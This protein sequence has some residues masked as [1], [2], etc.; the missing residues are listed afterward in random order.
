[1]SEAP[2][3]KVLAAIV[4]SAIKE[5]SAPLVARVA[6]LEQRAQA[7][8]AGV[9]TA[10]VPDLGVLA[11]IIVSAIKEYTAPMLARIAEIERLKDGGVDDAISV[12]LIQLQTRIKSLEARPAM[13]YK[14]SWKSD[15]SYDEGNMATHH[16]SLWHANE[17]SRGMP[18]GASDKWTLV[19]KRGADGRDSR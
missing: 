12:Q 19:A 2:N 9:S 1:M 16:G 3:P 17:Q 5:H 10:Q 4:A 11:D 18:P 14:G 13:I 7:L 15:L 8:K 6:V